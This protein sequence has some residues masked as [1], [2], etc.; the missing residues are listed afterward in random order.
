MGQTQC[1]TR[2]QGP[3]IQTARWKSQSALESMAKAA[4]SHTGAGTEETWVGVEQ[5]PLPVINEPGDIRGTFGGGW[6]PFAA[7]WPS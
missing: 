5:A 4:G 2:G 1:G 6:I 3:L 7:S